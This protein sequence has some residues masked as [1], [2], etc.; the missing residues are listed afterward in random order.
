MRVGTYN[1][2][3]DAFKDVG[4]RWE[5]R[6]VGV[7]QQLNDMNADLFGID[8]ALAHQ[9]QDLIHAF[10]EYGNIGV[11][12]DDGKTQGE[13]NLLFYRRSALTLIQSG[14]QWISST[15]HIPST[16]PDAGSRRI[17]VWGIFVEKATDQQ[18]LAI[19]T[20]LDD[21]SAAAR[22]LGAHQLL[23]LIA[24]PQFSALPVIL[25]GDFNMAAEDPAYQILA[26]TLIDATKDA[27][28]TAITPHTY[29]DFSEFIPHNPALFTQ[30]DYIFVNDRVQTLGITH[31]EQI[32]ATGR[33]PSDHFPIWGEFSLVSSR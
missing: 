27:D 19:V 32:T 11:G 21:G 31:G 33:Y 25:V 18:F 14:Y 26:D 1:I 13:Y 20:H 3:Y 29:Q 23:E 10:P 7:V 12:R 28:G 22:A 24:Q 9:R 17:I 30:L 6:R 8:E 15:P 2:R 4:W 16:F 5:Q